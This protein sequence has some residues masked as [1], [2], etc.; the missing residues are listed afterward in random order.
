MPGVRDAVGGYGGT[1]AGRVRSS[2]GYGGSAGTVE[3]HSV[4]RW[5]TVGTVGMG[6]TV[7]TVGTAG[8][9]AGTAAGNG[10]RYGRVRRVRGYGGGYGGYGPGPYGPYGPGSA[11][12]ADLRTEAAGDRLAG[13][14]AI[15]LVRRALVWENILLVDE[16]RKRFIFIMSLL[17]LLDRGGHLYGELSRVILKA[18]GYPVPRDRP[19]RSSARRRARPVAAVSSSGRGSSPEPARARAVRGRVEAPPSNRSDE[20]CNQR[21]HRTNDAN[22]RTTR[23]NERRMNERTRTNEP[24]PKTESEGHDSP[25]EDW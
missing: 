5:V 14:H 12:P 3:A 17:Q 4:D 19:H 22:E 20:N 8:T 15:A 1:A 23:T 25:S 13:A 16:T 7:G 11:D 10:G 21:A 24:N 2:L 18:M 6:V 9:A